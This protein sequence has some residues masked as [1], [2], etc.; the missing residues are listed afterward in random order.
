MIINV[1][2]GLSEEYLGVTEASGQ[3]R[4]EAQMRTPLLGPS[5][6]VCKMSF[7]FSLTG[8]SDHIGEKRLKSCAFLEQKCWPFNS[9]CA[10]GELSL[11]VIDSLLGVRPKMWE[12][13]GK[14]GPEEEAWQHAD[15]LIG[16]RKDRFQVGLAALALVSSE[17]SLNFKDPEYTTQTA[18]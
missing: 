6:P 10:A 16:V 18:V 3:Q 5:G 7:N 17:G 14:T 12:F 11:R 2:C 9:V 4:T 8:S 1:S 15:V 13:G